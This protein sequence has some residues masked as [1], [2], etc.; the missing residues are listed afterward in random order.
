MHRIAV[1]M[2]LWSFQAM[3]ES[4][5]VLKYRQISLNSKYGENESRTIATIGFAPCG[6]GL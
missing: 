5:R 4:N 1:A 2:S 3:A 6:L